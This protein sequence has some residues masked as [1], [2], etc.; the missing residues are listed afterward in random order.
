MGR[1]VVFSVWKPAPYALSSTGSSCPGSVLRNT[2]N[3]IAVEPTTRTL[4]VCG[5]RCPLLLP[6]SETSRQSPLEARHA[7]TRHRPLFG[8][9]KDIDI[10]YT[11]ELRK[12]S[13][14]D[15]TT[16]TPTASKRC[17][18]ASV[19]LARNWRNQQY[20][21]TKQYKVLGTS[22]PRN[23]RALRRSRAEINGRKRRSMAKY[24]R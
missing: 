1:R 14:R 8:D 20:I 17:I 7:A 16:R 22:T 15:G 21:I 13:R 19:G 24:I 10:Q 6:R 11:A 12:E 3:L 2:H 23:I 9:R 4:R 5:S 18:L